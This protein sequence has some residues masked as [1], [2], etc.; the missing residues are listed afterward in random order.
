MINPYLNNQINGLSK[1]ERIELKNS[2]LNTVVKIKVFPKFGFFTEHG[3]PVAV[4]TYEKRDRNN[5]PDEFIA[6]VI[7]VEPMVTI[8]ELP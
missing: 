3:F 1:Q 8:Y 2:L 5:F 7:A 4:A 6:K